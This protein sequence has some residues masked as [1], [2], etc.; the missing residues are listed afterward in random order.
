M[1]TGVRLVALPVAAVAACLTF[2]GAGLAGTT[3]ISGTVANG[4]CDAAR[5][6]P[7]SGASRIE[8][9]VSATTESGHVFGEIVRPDGSVAAQGTFDTPSGGAYSVRVCSQFESMDPPQIRYSGLIG[10]GPAGQPALPR[11]QGQVLGESIVIGHLAQGT[12]A[13]RTSAGLAWFTVRLGD[14]NRVTLRMFNPLTRQ[15]AVLT[16][17]RASFKS[18][19]KVNI[20]G[21]G[22]R[23][24]VIDTGR[25]DRLTF[26]SAR[27]KVSGIVVRGDYNVA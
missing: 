23:L 17:L 8:V 13:I 7:V 11:Q 15:H 3:S 5:P 10:T 20:T 6:V 16:G 25:F 21:K 26:R 27:L 19:D 4:G 9:T 14:N 1:S 18:R 22:I 24:V 12:G 2:A